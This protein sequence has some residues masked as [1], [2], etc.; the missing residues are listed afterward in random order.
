[1]ADNGDFVIA[2]LF[3]FH[4]ALGGD[5][6]ENVLIGVDI[7]AFEADHRFLGHRVE[8]DPGVEAQNPGQGFVFSTVFGEDA[9]ELSLFDVDD[10]EVGIRRE[11]HFCF[12]F[13]RVV[14]GDVVGAGFFVG[15]HDE[16]HPFL[17][18]YAVF[19]EG[20]HRVQ[21]G[22]KGPLVITDAAAVEAAVFFD[23]VKGVGDRPAFAGGHDVGVAQNVE[24]S[25]QILVI[26]GSADVIVVVGDG[27]AVILRQFQGFIQAL[28]RAVAERLAVFG[29]AFDRIDGT[30]R[31]DVGDHIR[32]MGI[33]P[34]IDCF[35]HRSIHSFLYS[36]QY[37][38]IRLNSIILAFSKILCKKIIL[39]I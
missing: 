30:Q 34:R 38:L 7:Q 15:A 18:L 20:A 21:S 2:G 35:V 36:I 22:D 27:E 5:I 12:R 31:L 33:E 37:K 14:M 8:G 4:F 24:G 11:G 1:M 9:L 23:D 16:A 26:I 32:Q 29:F 6:V 28:V 3:N 19:F 25:R 39:I 10:R 13:R 17:E